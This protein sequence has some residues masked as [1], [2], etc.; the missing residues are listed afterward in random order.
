MKYA[1]VTPIHKEDDKTDKENHCPISILP[2][3]SKVC[4]I[5]TIRG[6]NKEFYIVV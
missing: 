4:E 5:Q 3:V 2:D 1:K 6:R